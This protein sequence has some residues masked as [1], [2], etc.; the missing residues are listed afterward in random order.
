LIRGGSGS[1]LLS[2]QETLIKINKISLLRMNPRKRIPW[3]KDEY[4]QYNVGGGMKITYTKISL[5]EEIK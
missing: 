1:N 5:V 4:H 3:G 2:I